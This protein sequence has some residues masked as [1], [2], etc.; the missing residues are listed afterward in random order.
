MIYMR[1]QTIT[2]GLAPHV[3][4]HFMFKGLLKGC[5]QGVAMLY[6]AQS[7]LFKNGGD[8]K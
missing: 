4:S 7:V 3:R 8:A 2:W 6:M 1:K 5:M